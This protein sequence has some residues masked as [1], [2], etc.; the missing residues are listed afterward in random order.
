MKIGIV[1]DFSPDYSSQVAINDALMHSSRK[2]GMFIEYEWIPTAT[3]MNQLDSL[4]EIYQGYWIGPGYPDSMDGVLRIIQFA[5]EHNLPLLGT[6]GG[7]QYMI[8]EYVRNKMMLKNVGHEERDPQAIQ[9]VISKLTCSLVGQKGEVFIKKP[10]RSFG[11][12]QVENVIEQFRCNYGLNAEYKK[13][14]HEAGLRIVGTDSVGNPRIIELP[15]HKFFIG[16]LFVPQLSSTT[17]STHC[18]VDSFITTLISS[19]ED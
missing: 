11:M 16:T 3:I 6:C 1:G 7:F 14:I 15:E 5:R 2:L 18:I 19:S 8:M 12:Y 17:D 9:L 10:S 13:Q 4:M